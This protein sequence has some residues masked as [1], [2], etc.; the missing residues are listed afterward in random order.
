MVNTETLNQAIEENLNTLE[1]I[2]RSEFAAH[3]KKDILAW[4]QKLKTMHQNLEIWIDAQRYW[5]N[6]DIIYNS[7]LFA[8]IFGASTKQFISTR[9]QFQ[10]IMWSSYKNPKAIYNLMIE[11]RIKVFREMRVHF[12]VL[13]SKVHDYLEQKRLV[14]S[15]F[16]FLNDSQFLEFLTL[17]NT[18]QDFS[19]YVNT[20]FVGAQNLY[21]QPADQVKLQRNEGGADGGEGSREQDEISEE[22]DSLL[23][24]EEGGTQEQASAMTGLQSVENSK[25]GIEGVNEYQVLGLISPNKELFLFESPVQVQ[26]D[27]LAIKEVEG[28]EVSGTGT[29]NVEQWLIK[30]ERSMQE[31]MQKQMQYAVKSFATRALD[32]WVLDYPQ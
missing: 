3:I 24:D 12:Q 16:F 30:V 9:L 23:S 25:M 18:S 22:D 19:T 2:S 15:R 29:G 32:E 1:V 13:Q 21:I 31:T 11:S 26:N 8:N 6:L 5:V 4:L 14:F 7:G 28:Y 17:A 10:R 27:N 20:L